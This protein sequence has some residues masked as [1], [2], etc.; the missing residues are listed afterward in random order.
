MEI[1]LLG[2][3]HL[4]A[5]SGGS[6]VAQMSLSVI[7]RLSLSLLL[8]VGIIGAES[9]SYCPSSHSDR[10]LTLLRRM[11]VPLPCTVCS[12]SELVSRNLSAHSVAHPAATALRRGG[13]GGAGERRFYEIAS[14]ILSTSISH[15]DCNAITA[16]KA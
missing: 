14:E 12:A 2:S 6:S 16:T 13:G 5:C 10:H 1:G 11:G 7:G 15:F 9:A 8:C 3:L 4:P